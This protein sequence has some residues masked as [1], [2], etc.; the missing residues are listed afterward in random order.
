M[1][2][3]DEHSGSEAPTEQVALYEERSGESTAD[4]PLVEADR[5]G[6]PS[7][8][9]RTIRQEAYR[10][11]PLPESKVT[12]Q[13]AAPKEVEADAQT[14]SE[15]AGRAVVLAVL[16]EGPALE[17]LSPTAAEALQ[18]VL[19]G[20]VARMLT[21][22]GTPNGPLHFSAPSA[23]AAARAAFEI[24]QRVEGH[25]HDSQA[26]IAVRIGLGVSSPIALGLARV[27]ADG[28]VVADAAARDAVGPDHC[29]SERVG[30]RQVADDLPLVMAYRLESVSMTWAI[31]QHRE[32]QSPRRPWWSRLWRREP[33]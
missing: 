23:L 9:A 24:L 10:P 30:K 29:R 33:R 8:E 6:T 18:Q 5:I 1:G 26:R 15:E 3:D 22:L 11:P 13:A 32:T 25:N 27:A 28:E 17:A 31:P 12:V 19:V 4:V 20:E 16:L 7:S 14:D 2:K 21:P